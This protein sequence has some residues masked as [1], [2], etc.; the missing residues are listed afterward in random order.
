MRDSGLELLRRGKTRLPLAVRLRLGLAALVLSWERLWPRLW[1]ALG[2]A[3]LALVAGLSGVLPLLPG[4]LHLL[5]LVLLAAGFLFGLW[6]GV[7]GFRLPEMQAMRR[8]LERDSDLPHRPLSSLDD[9]QATGYEDASTRTLWR[10]HRKR[11]IRNLRHLR[12]RPPRASLAGVD[13]LGLRALLA[14]LLVIAAVGAGDEWRARLGQALA[15]DLR[16]ASAAEQRAMLDIWVNPPAYTGQPPRFL[17]LADSVEEAGD[18][19]PVLGLPLGSRVLARFQSEGEEPALTIGQSRHPFKQVA[20]GAYKVEA[21]IDKGEH[22]AVGHDDDDI[23][24]RWRVSVVPDEDPTAEFVSPPSRTERAALRIDYAATDDYGVKSLSLS[25]SRT[26]AS[27]D[28]PL[29][30]ELPLTPGDRTS[31][32]GA[33]YFDLTSHV[34]AGLPVEITLVATDAIGQAG[35]SGTFR[36]VLPERIFSHPLARALVELRKR[37]SVDPEGARFEVANTLAALYERPSHYFGDIVVGL[38]MKTAERRLVYDSGANAIAEVQQLLWEAA[39]RL[40]DGDLAIAERDLRDAQQRLME[41]LARGASDE[42]IQRLMDELERALDRYLE[43]MAEQL[44]DR[45]SENQDL[46]PPPDNAQV[47]GQRDLQEMIQTMRELAQNGARQAA[48]ELLQQ[49]QQI[50]ENLQMQPFAQQMTEQQRRAMRMMRDMD[51]LMREQ[52]NLLDRSFRRSQEGRPGETGSRGRTG[53]QGERSS[54]GSQALGQSLQDADSQEALRRALGDMMRQLGEALGE[55]PQPMGRAEQQMRGA[56]DALRRNAPGEAI[57]PQTRALDFLQQ[58]IS[59]LAD[60]LSEQMMDQPGGGQGRIGARPG[61]QP[62]PLGRR[63]GGQG[64]ESTEGVEIPAGADI[65]RAQ[66]ILRELRRRAGERSR[67]EIERNYIDR[68]LDRF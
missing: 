23:L 55:I 38:T 68:L 58:G 5:V 51:Q 28:A 52:R 61:Q 39:L 24:A 41:A 63:P 12:V 2:V 65:Q 15:P 14:L 59:E 25:I 49:M 53:R 27:D 10:I 26:D 62:D 44:R 33:S 57:G 6:R 8:R 3:G 66:E 13:P 35:S 20:P 29:Q 36:T 64:V 7:R 40:E 4:W 21:V 11:M 34:W 50:L 42:E 46:P 67:P 47:L 9:L 32:D 54:E 30:L 22:I 60:R 19:A 18:G 17:D 45:M 43:A 37:L 16:S 1:P 48:Q 56:E 31:L